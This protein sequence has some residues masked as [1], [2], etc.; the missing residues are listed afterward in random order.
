MGTITKG[1][2]WVDNENVTYTDLNGNFDTVYNEV[3]GSLDDDNVDSDAAIQ[4]SK[5]LFSATGHGHTGGA[6]GKAIT[7]N[8]AYGFYIAG[9][10]SV[11]ND[12]SWNPRVYAAQT[13]VRISA[14]AQTAP[15]GADLIVR[16]YN[17]TQD[18]VVATVTISASG[19][20]ATSTSMTNASLTAGDILRADVT[21]V[22]S[23]VAG[24]DISLILDVTES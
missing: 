1:K 7:K 12:L 5:I 21:Q 18:E 15:T 11:A 9:T 16:V 8:R 14:H 13:G 6:D 17:I 23:T 4:E 2:T 19:T 20:D 24:A 3:N 22:G 10:P